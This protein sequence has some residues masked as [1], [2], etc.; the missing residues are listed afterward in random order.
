LARVGCRWLVGNRCGNRSCACRAACPLGPRIVG[1]VRLFAR[2]HR[3]ALPTSSRT[4]WLFGQ[5]IDG[6]RPQETRL[7]AGQHSQDQTMP[8][9]QVAIPERMVRRAHLPPVQVY[10]RVAERRGQQITLAPRDHS[11]T[12]RIALQ[13][14][15]ECFSLAQ[16]AA[17][18]NASQLS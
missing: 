4:P 2:A 12:S 7:R 14:A 18:L 1:R 6:R 13:M 3:T 5:S 8:R 11:H 17:M 16:G 15:R 10:R 9:L